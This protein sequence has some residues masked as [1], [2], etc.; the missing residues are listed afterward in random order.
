MIEGLIDLGGCTVCPGADAPAELPSV[1]VVNK[2]V[3]SLCKLD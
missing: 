1:I 3:H 2:V